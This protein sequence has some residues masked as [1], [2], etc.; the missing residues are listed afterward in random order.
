MIAFLLSFIAC[1]APAAQYDESELTPAVAAELEAALAR[2]EADDAHAELYRLA[3][4]EWSSVDPVLD[5]LED[6][7]LGSDDQERARNARWLESHLEWNDGRLRSARSRM[8]HLDEDFPS[9]QTH[10]A[11]GCL[12]DTLDDRDAAREAYEAALEASPDAAFEARL[13]LRLAMLELGV[14][15]DDDEEMQKAA[16][17]LIAFGEE[18]GRSDDDRNRAAVV[19]SLDGRF[20]AAI[21]LFRVGDESTGQGEAFRRELRD[22]EWA[23]RAE[24]ADAAKEHALRAVQLAGPKRDRRYALGILV[25]AHRLDDSLGDLVAILEANEDRTDE[26]TQVWI[27]LLRE[28]GRFE[29]ALA[30]FRSSEEEGGGQLDDEVRRQLLDL[31]R[32]WGRE[33]LLEREYRN[34]VAAHPASI[35]W[36]EGLS[37]FLIE[38]GRPDEAR[39]VWSDYL[40]DDALAPYVLTAAESMAGLG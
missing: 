34:L 23:I 14:Q 35:V 4:L 21:D 3:M 39:A 15:S 33:D 10:W 40:T 18:E 6:V 30:W 32:E 7:V 16:E 13:R 25:E 29:E 8:Q 11:L 2:G 36:R 5:A 28:T 27:D 9:A 37:R 20:E 22:A 24:K 19:L 38:K 1:A 12:C 31:C 17:A 26:E